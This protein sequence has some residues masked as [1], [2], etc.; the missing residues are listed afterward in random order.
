MH[1]S[2]ASPGCRPLSPCSIKLERPNISFE[3]SGRSLI[4]Y[5][6]VFM[7]LEWSSLKCIFPHRNG[8]SITHILLVMI[9]FFFTFSRISLCNFN[10]VM[11]QFSIILMINPRHMFCLIVLKN[12]CF[13]AFIKRMSYSLCDPILQRFGR[14]LDHRSVS[15]GC[16][17]F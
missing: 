17:L 14:H 5:A 6:P 8:P 12:C 9:V 3:G 13:F 1:P 4:V 11:K 10:V 16:M 2:D 7:M 15:A